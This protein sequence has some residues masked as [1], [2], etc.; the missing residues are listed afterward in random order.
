[1]QGHGGRM[2]GPKAEG[3]KD[4]WGT[5]KRLVGFMGPWKWAFV[6]VF[7]FAIGSVI[8]QII[9]PKILGGA[10]TEIYIGIKKGLASGQI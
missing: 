10:T 6:L 3:A 5:V 2:K 4:F 9:T 8:F 7:I 1:M